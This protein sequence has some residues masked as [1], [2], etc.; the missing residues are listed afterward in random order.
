MN[1]STRKT[2]TGD[3]YYVPRPVHVDHAKNHVP[4]RLVTNFRSRGMIGTCGHAGL[5]RPRDTLLFHVHGGGFIAQ[6]PLSH[7]GKISYN[8]HQSCF[9]Q[10]VPK[11]CYYDECENG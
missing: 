10:E 4:A 9:I 2:T 6:S 8:N 3:K 7:I 11:K 1:L 5:A